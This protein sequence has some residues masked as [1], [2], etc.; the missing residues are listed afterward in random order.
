[1]VAFGEEAEPIEAIKGLTAAA[2]ANMR[3]QLRV[4]MLSRDD[5]VALGQMLGVAPLI[6]E[7]LADVELL[8]AEPDADAIARGDAEELANLAHRSLTD[9]ASSL[10]ERRKIAGGVAIQML[11]NAGVPLRPAE[12]AIAIAEVIAQQPGQGPA[13]PFKTLTNDKLVWTS[14]AKSVGGILGDTFGNK[15]LIG[16]LLDAVGGGKF[17]D[18][19]LRD[20]FDGLIH[21]FGLRPTRAR[22]H[23]NVPVPPPPSKLP[24]PLIEPNTQEQEYLAR[25][26]LNAQI[27]QTWTLLTACSNKAVGL[28]F[29]AVPLP[30]TGPHLDTTT[31]LEDMTGYLNKLLSLLR[32]CRS[33]TEPNVPGSGPP[34]PR[35]GV[36]PGPSQPRPPGNLTEFEPPPAA[37]P[38]AA[39]PPAAP[40]PAV[41]PPP[42]VPTEPPSA[43]PPPTPPSTP[44]PPAPP[45][46]APAPPSTPPPAPPPRPQYLVDQ[47]WRDDPAVAATLVSYPDMSGVPQ[48]FNA[49]LGRD[50]TVAE[51]VTWVPIA[52]RTTWATFDQ[53][54]RAT[55]LGEAPPPGQ[56]PPPPP[57]KPGVF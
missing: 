17:N 40:P 54:L 18:D 38:P 9:L 15:T 48:H 21:T 8:H 31:S 4:G 36:E 41:P 55:Y 14:V 28:G 35:G 32:A 7:Q 47:S 51:M 37:P 16:G 11:V 42:R 53:L 25:M 46:P 43:P 30:E 33:V 44:P 57:P 6:L 29:E 3:A 23:K 50:P 56:T 19:H 22:E 34:K 24:P 10:V 49:Q 52:G 1:V 2:L 27:A 20:I 39:P 26:S 5:F 13:W 12:I 45:P